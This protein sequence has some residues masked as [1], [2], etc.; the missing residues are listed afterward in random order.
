MLFVG[1]SVACEF[2]RFEVAK[3]NT[4]FP[5]PHARVREN[6][7]HSHASFYTSHTSRFQGCANT[8]Q[9]VSR[10]H[11][12]VRETQMFAFFPQPITIQHSATRRE[13]DIQFYVGSLVIGVPGNLNRMSVSKR[14][15]KNC[16]T[17]FYLLVFMKVQIFQRI[18]QQM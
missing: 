13:R 17:C 5:P 9:N 16:W 8:G 6:V 2:S 1:D 11:V 10:S 7:L 14:Q 3:K 15:K 4:T 18:L 12:G